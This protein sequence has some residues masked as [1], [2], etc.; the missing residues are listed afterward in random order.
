MVTGF[1]RLSLLARICLTCLALVGLSVVD[2]QPMPEAANSREATG[3]QPAH[4]VAADAFA[5]DVALAGVVAA[6]RSLQILPEVPASIELPAPTATAVPP[7]PTPEPPPGPQWARVRSETPLRLSSDSGAPEA[8]F[9]PVGSYLRILG[10]EAGRY[11]VHY[12]GNG[13]DLDPGEGWVDPGEVD[14]TPAPRWVEALEGT[15]LWSGATA[16][17]RL[18]V[19]PAGAVVEVL[20]DRGRRLHVF[21]LGDGHTRGQAEGW[22]N[23]DTLGPAGPLIVAEKWGLRVMTRSDVQ[24]I[25]AGEGVWMRVP[26][27]TQLDGSPSEDSNCGPVSIGM[28]LQFFHLGVP[29]AELRSIA[30]EL[31]GTSDPEL[32]FSIQFLEGTVDRVGLRGVELEIEPERLKPWTI[33]DVR[34]HLGQGHPVIVEL[35]YNA[36]PGRSMAAF[37]E[38]HYVVLTGMLGDDFIY[39]DSVDVDGP[40]Y[41][42]LISEEDLKLAWGSS[43][44]PWA[45]F[46]VSAP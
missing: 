27:R 43:Y 26:F 16:R 23:V 18:A 41:G 12:G 1:P 32:G 36:M 46:A 13:D 15:V 28:A 37:A 17:D 10:L 22:V 30:E 42:R 20:E 5:A 29:T 6:S 7:S 24:A 31:Q 40:G 19:L 35:R 3:S 14:V 2:Q 34:R 21:Y 39:N 25:E 45:A 11:R 38:D 33:D 4:A 44:F 9:L 8:H